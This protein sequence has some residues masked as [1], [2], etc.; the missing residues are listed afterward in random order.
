VLSRL[1]TGSDWTG[2]ELRSYDV[3]TPVPLHPRRLYER[4]YNQALLL[5]REIGSLWEMPVNDTD[6]VRSR[7]TMP[8]IQ[9]SP[10]ERERNVKGAFTVVGDGFRD[11]R[12]VLVDD[13]YTTG[14]TVAECARTLSRC[15]AQS[16]GV[17]TLARVVIK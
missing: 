7:W 11:K 3:M 17:L 12:V 2:C 16:V 13:V 5:C 6:L 14:A 15:G 4:G 1:V 9:L 8:Q 10:K